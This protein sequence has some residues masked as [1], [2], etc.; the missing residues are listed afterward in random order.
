MMKTG[1]TTFPA[2]FPGPEFV[3]C[4]ETKD[5]TTLLLLKIDEDSAR[6]H[7]TGICFLNSY[8]NTAS[9]IYVVS[10]SYNPKEY[11]LARGKVYKDQFKY[12]PE[13]LLQ[14]EVLLNHLKGMPP[15]R[16]VLE[17][18]CGFGRITD[19][20]LS[21]F[22]GIQEY[23]A[24]DMS[25]DQLE[26]AKKFV[27]K[28]DKVQFIESDIQSLQLGKK[29]DL[30]I[31]VSVLLHI[32]PSE[33]D[34]VAAKFVSF[35]KRHVINVDYYEEGEARQVA[36]HNFMHQYEKIYKS[37]PSVESVTR[38]PV[39]KKKTLS[40]LDAKMSIFHALVKAD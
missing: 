24:M 1:F 6:M 21:N 17:I 11:W 38:I 40:K 19:L 20:I 4:M 13:K 31:A 10:T 15:F 12:D 7:S 30:V 37:L 26:N 2:A 27:A 36:P 29:Y 3:V 14:E 32:L 39:V 33:I 18:G 34:Q 5:Q 22:P 25:P 23:V 35:S 28:S 16:S 8:I 9:W